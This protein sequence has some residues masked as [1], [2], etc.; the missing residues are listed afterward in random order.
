LSTDTSSVR[1]PR[2]SYQQ[3]VVIRQTE[4]QRKAG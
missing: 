1:F 2:R 3:L 4:R